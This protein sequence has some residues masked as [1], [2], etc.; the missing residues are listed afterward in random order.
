MFVNDKILEPTA[1][2]NGFS[3][4]RRIIS[5]NRDYICL[6]LTIWL[7]FKKSTTIKKSEWLTLRRKLLYEVKCTSMP[8]YWLLRLYLFLIAAERSKAAHYSWHSLAPVSCVELCKAD[9]NL[10]L[11]DFW[12]LTDF[13][14]YFD[15]TD[16]F[17]CSIKLHSPGCHLNGSNIVRTPHKRHNKVCN[18][19]S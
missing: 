16:V 19:L 9:F 10:D 8:K 17:S 2:L 4:I 12:M 13:M 5:Y 11:L 15:V 1:D 3:L 14:T 18:L 7:F 6:C